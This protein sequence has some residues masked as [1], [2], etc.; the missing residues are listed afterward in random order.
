MP[1]ACS[2]NPFADRRGSFLQRLRNDVNQGRTIIIEG[3]A[4][5]AFQLCRIFNRVG[6]YTEGIG[7]C[8]VICPAEIDREVAFI[9]AR[10]LTC[11]DPA[12]YRV[13]KHNEGNWHVL[14]DNSFQF[15][16]GKAEAA[17]AHHGNDLLIRSPNVG[18][19]GCR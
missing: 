12:K 11:L 18:P 15:A 6:L 2:R 17:I 3:F 4:E 1:V 16:A 19:H 5:H 13:G 7:H 9:E 8:S 10:F 14:A